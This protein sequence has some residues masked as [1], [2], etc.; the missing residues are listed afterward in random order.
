MTS[1]GKMTE[2]EQLFLTKKCYLKGTDDNACK[3]TLKNA[4]TKRRLKKKNIYLIYYKHARVVS[5]SQPSSG[6]EK[7]FCWPVLFLKILIWE[8]FLECE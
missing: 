5:D 8:A 3:K 1:N 6:Q 7:K 2:I 4:T